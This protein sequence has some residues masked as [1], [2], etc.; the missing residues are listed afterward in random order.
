M[1]VSPVSLKTLQRRHSLW[2]AKCHPDLMGKSWDV[3]PALP[4]FWMQWI[5]TGIV[6]KTCTWIKGISPLNL[7]PTKAMFIWWN[8]FE[9]FRLIQCS[10]QSLKQVTSHSQKFL[11]TKQG[12]SCRFFMLSNPCTV[13]NENAWAPRPKWSVPSVPW[14]VHCMYYNRLEMKLV[15]LWESL[16]SA[17]K[18]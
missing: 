13:E 11:T 5:H 7:F 10:Q 14:S 1:S 12:K 16:E 6:L 15:V 17:L 18:E 4:P 9:L 8:P 3:S 2:R